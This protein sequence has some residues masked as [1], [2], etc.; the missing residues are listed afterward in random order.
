M[1]LQASDLP[2][3]Y[4][5]FDEGSLAR[6]DM[7]QGPRGDP[8]RFGRKGGWKARYRR[9]GSRRI[10]GPLVIES[11]A[12]LFETD[13]GAV[14]DL[15]AHR[16]ELRAAVE[17]S[18]GAARLLPDPGFAD[19]GTAMSLTQGSGRRAVR[20]LTV[21]WRID[22]ATASVVVSGF[23]GGVSLE[24]VIALARAQDRRMAGAT[25]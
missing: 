11:R 5:Q 19:E 12:D 10:S 17:A 3:T 16:E 24:E 20:F 14:K 2:N 22:N 18:D 9:L 23:A 25:C 13:D 8:F 6:A 1:V 4:E 7:P 21:A 15:G